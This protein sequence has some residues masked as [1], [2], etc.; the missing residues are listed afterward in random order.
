P[1]RSPSPCGSAT[2]GAFRRGHFPAHIRMA[3]EHPVAAGEN[4]QPARL[5]ALSGLAF[6]PSLLSVES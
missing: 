3:L 2:D 1:S 6:R 4:Y 5:P